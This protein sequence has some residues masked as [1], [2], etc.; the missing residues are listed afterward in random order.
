MSTLLDSA[1][2]ISSSSTILHKALETGFNLAIWERAPIENAAALIDN[3]KGDVRFTAPVTELEPIL[4]D[5]LSQAGFIDGRVRDTFA[6]DILHLAQVYSS[7][8][9]LERITVRVELVTTNSCRKWH[10][11]YVTARLITTYVGSGTE[12]IDDRD[13]ARVRNGLAPRQVNSLKAGDVGLFQGKLG[14]D[15]PAIHR[16][17]PIEGTGE[18]RLLLVLNPAEDA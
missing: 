18:K 1:P 3:D 2:A 4:S 9:D 11:D 14:T 17:P 10:A 6:A 5:A 12:W 16:S 7:I 13:A 8:L 15:T